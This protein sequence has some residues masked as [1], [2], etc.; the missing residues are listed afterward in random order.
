MSPRK[1]PLPKAVARALAPKSTGV[2]QKTSARKTNYRSW[3]EKIAILDHYH[4]WSEA[5]KVQG[6]IPRV[7]AFENQFYKRGQVSRLLP[8]EKD[9]RSL[10]ETMPQ[11][12]SQER[13]K[14]QARPFAPVELLLYDWLRYFRERHIPINHKLLRLMAQDI[15]R[16]WVAHHGLLTDHQG[17]R[18]NWSSDWA[19]KFIKAWSLD[20]YKMTGESSSVDLSLIQGEL[21]IIKKIL[22]EYPLADIYNC[23]ETG[24]YT[25]W[26]TNW[27]LDIIRRAGVKPQKGDRVSALFCANA[28]GTDK[29][30]PLILCKPH[31]Y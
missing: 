18:P 10:K 29:R 22:D 7:L 12:T 28:L 23:D 11:K 21:D 9:L 24:V 2:A 27:T 19:R 17:R 6:C 8:L 13:S 20:Y 5:L 26:M 14:T 30:R 15:Y 1:K 31:C 4:T 16:S 3:A 25:K